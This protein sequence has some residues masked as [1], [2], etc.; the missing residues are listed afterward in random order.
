MTGQKLN[1]LA[2]YVFGPMVFVAID[3]AVWM[4][5]W[6]LGVDGAVCSI[7]GLIC[8]V[9][10]LVGGVMFESDQAELRKQAQ[11]D[12]ERAETSAR[13]AAREKEIEFE[14]AKLKEA[15]EARTKKATAS[16]KEP[17]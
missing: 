10:A 5:P 14:K 11:R 6:S 1:Q 16:P 12:H 3:M 2:L 7:A 15:R 8:V 9:L 17:K 4:L 13:I